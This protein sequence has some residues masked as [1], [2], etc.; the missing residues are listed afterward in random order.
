MKKTALISIILYIACGLLTGC[1]KKQPAPGFVLYYLNNDNT[2]FVTAECEFTASDNETQVGEIMDMLSTISPKNAYVAPIGGLFPLKSYTVNQD[3]VT[4]NFTKEY[5]KVETIS[6]ILGRAAVVKSLTQLPNIRSVIFTVEGEP[7]V[8]ADGTIIGAMTSDMFI[9]NAGKEINAYEQTK[10][11]IYMASDDGTRLIK[12][13]RTVVYNTNISKEHLVMNE[14]IEGLQENEQGLPVINP[15]TKLI[16]TTVT[17][18]ICYVNLSDNF[19]AQ[20]YTVLPEITIYSIVNSLVELEG[21]NK[22]QILVN[23]D[24]SGVFRETMPLSQI[25]ERNLDLV[26]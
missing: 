10:I 3:Q 11:Y 17:D 18:G 14:L 5:L 19:L 23:G 6:E 26:D 7:I 4:L 12:I 24:T 22:V 1:A 16:S 21:V 8:D 15:E 9:M 2:G 13:P 20:P 25:Y